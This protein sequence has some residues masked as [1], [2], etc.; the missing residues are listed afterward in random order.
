MNRLAVHR[1]AVDCAVGHQFV[2]LRYDVGP[3]HLVRRLALARLV[4]IR[5]DSK[6]C[7]FK[8]TCI[9]R[10][11]LANQN[12][13]KMLGGGFNF[14]DVCGNELGGK[15]RKGFHQVRH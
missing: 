5:A 6:I 15:N 11:V 4:S 10:V 12:Q 3:D 1:T 7:I 14:F 9:G 2:E 8:A 13:V